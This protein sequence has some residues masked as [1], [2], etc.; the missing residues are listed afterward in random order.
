[1]Q[2]AAFLL[3]SWNDSQ[4]GIQGTLPL[5]FRYDQTYLHHVFVGFETFFTFNRKIEKSQENNSRIQR[6]LAGRSRV[7]SP[8]NLAFLGASPAE[9]DVT[10]PKQWTQQ[11]GT[12]SVD[13]GIGVKVDSSKNIYVMESPTEELLGM[14]ILWEMISFQ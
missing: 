3:Y 8:G 2:N 10:K 12:S 7:E 5:R 6:S 11:L 9:R 14:L 4:K 13:S 1:M